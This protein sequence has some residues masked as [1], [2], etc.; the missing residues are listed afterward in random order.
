MSGA[1]DVL[2]RIDGLA[3]DVLL[4][5]DYLFNG[6][7]HAE[8][9]AGDHD[10]VGVLDDL[11]D[12]LNGLVVLDLADEV[13]VGPV[14]GVLLLEVLAQLGEVGPVPREGYG[15]VVDLVL[16][17]ELDYIVLVVSA[18]GRKGDLDSGQAHVLLV[19]EL[20]VVQHL[21]CHYPVLH[22]LHH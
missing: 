14:L 9:P 5:E 19:A 3:H 18:D 8:V 21:H 17:A 20:A 10:A 6:E 16:D 2:A 12:V 7:L 15:D 11:V 22:L 4:R 1:D 13:D